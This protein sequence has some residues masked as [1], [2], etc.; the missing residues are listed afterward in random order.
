MIWNE[1]NISN[2]INEL[3]A[4]LEIDYMPTHKQMKDNRLSGLSMAIN[5]QG[6]TDY[7]RE[8]L[9]LER[10]RKPP[11]KWTDDKIE[12]GV[13][14]CMKT[15]AIDRMPSSTEF[16]DIGRT[17]IHCALSKHPLKYSGWAEKLGIKQKSSDTVKGQK[18]EV[19]LENILKA[20]EY[21]VERMT[22]KYPYDFVV[23]EHVKV[24]VK[25]GAPHHHFGT[26]CH[27]F[28][29]S[30]KHPTCDL[31]ICIAL[32]E[33][34]EI[35]K[36]FVIPSKFAQIVTLNICNDSKYNAFIDRWDYIDRYTEFYERLTI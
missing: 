28:R 5:K 15:L 1:Q 6:G 17:D 18:Y 11:I 2:A 24:D 30:K 7:W 20:K 13:K 22:T 27:T 3:M 19:I 25:V 32:D 34:E 23:N 21:E 10:K 4:S 36:I 16:K 29:P 33:Q 14:E 9:G 26:R 31:Y 12:A 8:K 35:E